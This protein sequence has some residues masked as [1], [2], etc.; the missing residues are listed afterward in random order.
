MSVVT[1]RLVLLSVL[2]KWN[3]DI[4]QINGTFASLIIWLSLESSSAFGSC[5]WWLIVVEY[6]DEGGHVR[7]LLIRVVIPFDETF[8]PAEHQIQ[9]GRRKSLQFLQLQIITENGHLH[10]MLEKISA[11]M[12][13][14]WLM[15]ES[16][17][18]T[19]A[20]LFPHKVNWTD[21]SAKGPRSI[22]TSHSL[23][24][25]LSGRETVF[26]DIPTCI[27]KH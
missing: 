21:A 18:T 22:V 27:S 4:H 9:F 1:S 3:A 16:H 12:Y 14:A 25:L 10:L 15:K 19:V 11:E 13:C 8:G 6:F 17:T 23:D 26:I 5:Q 24:Q 2:T 7:Y 20:L